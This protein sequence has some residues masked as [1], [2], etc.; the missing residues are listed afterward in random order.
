MKNNKL[1]KFLDI[2]TRGEQLDLLM[3][4]FLEEKFDDELKSKYS[5]ILQEDLDVKRSG[6][7]KR[8]K[9]RSYLKVA[10]ILIL[11]V[12]AAIGAY[13]IMNSLRGGSDGVQ[14]YLAQHQL[15]F[16]D[17][18]RN[19]AAVLS[20]SKSAAYLEF[21]KGAYEEYL[22]MIST[23]TDRSADDQ[24]FI[25]YA[26]MMEDDFSGALQALEIFC[27]DLQ[28]EQKYYQEANLYKAI[29]LLKTDENKF[30][31]YFKT[32]ANDSWIKGE[33]DKMR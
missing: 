26:R 8:L 4:E 29:C 33:L 17:S 9:P 13:F 27:T 16:Q 31:D 3:K 6:K 19:D 24:F 15:L 10:S 2:E 1:K 12:G 22:K 11:L 7:V 28:P 23:V 25:G 21:N 30:D 5:K 20:P 18:N 32:L 14:Q